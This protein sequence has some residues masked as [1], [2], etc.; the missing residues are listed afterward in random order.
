[1]LIHVN[2]TD[3]PPIIPTDICGT[4]DFKEWGGI[5]EHTKISI[6]TYIHTYIYIHANIYMYIY[7][8]LIDV[9]VLSYFIFIMQ[10]FHAQ[11][12]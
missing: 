6:H 5:R 11:A 7:V 1:M 2:H 3:F 9:K 4:S 12:V 10:Y 8:I